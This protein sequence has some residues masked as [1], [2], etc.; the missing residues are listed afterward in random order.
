LIRQ[1]PYTAPVVDSLAIKV[2]VDS[3][4]ENLLP[5]ESHPFVQIDHLGDIPGKMVHTLAAEWGL[6]LH[7]ASTSSGD[8][9]EYL[10]DF[11]WTPDVINRNFDLLD[12]EPSRLNGLVLSHG[13]LD[14][15]GGLDGFLDKFRQ[16]MRDD[17]SLFVGGEEVFA[18]RWAE[19][20][21]DQDENGNPA[22]IQWGELTREQ[23]TAHKVETVCCAGPRELGNS[24]S[25]GYIQR[26]SFEST[27]S[28]TLIRCADH[29]SEQERAGKMIVDNHPEEHAICYLVRGRGLVVISA[30]SHVG[31]INAVKT[32]LAVTGVEKLHAVV[33]GFH[34]A[35]SNQE[36][37]NHTVDVFEELNPDVVLPM[38]CSGPSFIETMRNRMPE[39][40]VRANL[41]SRYVFGL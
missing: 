34:L 5:Q 8:R 18:E 37:V 27:T 41:G 33:G 12:I 11:G 3:R 10:L 14:H 22:M 6:S 25:T 38:H 21:V 16:S 31:I 32:S 35:A 2:V 17:L 36:Y 29:F 24:F 39:K 1:K 19:D 40:L 4:Y 28:H 23:L 15:Y 7:L 9:F 30:C 26:D 20:P 13:H